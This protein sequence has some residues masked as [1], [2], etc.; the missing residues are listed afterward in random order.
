[1][2][3]VEILG[4]LPKHPMTIAGATNSHGH[5]DRKKADKILDP[6]GWFAYN[7]QAIKKTKTMPK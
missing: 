2:K 1:M 7:K 6:K 4:Q 5:V 3:I